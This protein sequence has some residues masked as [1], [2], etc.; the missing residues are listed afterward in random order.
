MDGKATLMKDHFDR[1]ASGYRELRKTD[2]EPVEYLANLIVDGDDDTRLLDLGCGTGR[3][4]EALLDC[5]SIPLNL[6]CVDTSE[7]MLR[8]CRDKLWNHRSAKSCFL[9]QAK[10]DKIPFDKGLLD[11]MVTFNA[12][13]HFDIAKFFDEAARVLKPGGFLGIYTRSRAQNKKTIWGRYFPR[14][15]ERENRLLSIEE[16][17]RIIS[18]RRDLRV[19]EIKTYNFK[20]VISIDWLMQLVSGHHYS[21]FKF[22]TPE[23]LKKATAIFERRLKTRF[24]DLENIPHDSNYTLLL[25]RKR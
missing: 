17:E 3:Y 5:L 13:H 25:V 14:F 9:L 15:V 21:T 20:R 24:D 7:E 23:E 19:E 4:T 22:Y 2:C 10:A 12:I 16:F 18:R 6:Y 11:F 8:L 1:I